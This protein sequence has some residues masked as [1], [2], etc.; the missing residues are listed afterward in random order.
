[1][2]GR[3]AKSQDGRELRDIDT[4]NTIMGGEM[5]T[6]LDLAKTRKSTRSYK[7]QKISRQDL[8][9]CAEAARYAPS[10]CNS[11]PWKFIIVDDPALKNSIKNE[12]FSGIYSL[13][14]FA[15]NATAFIIQISE[16]IKRPAWL[17]GQLTNTNFRL[18][19]TGIACSHVVLQAQELG[20]GSCILGWFNHKKLKKA[21]NI[22]RNK[23]VELVIALGYPGNPAAKKKTVKNC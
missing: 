7:D 3:K 12:A 22:P 8:E 5:N 2:R 6:F 11:Q 16:K 15:G 20:I 14:T 17:A 13:N 21:L 23:K 1:M 19:D 18:I 10:A 4:T 9:L